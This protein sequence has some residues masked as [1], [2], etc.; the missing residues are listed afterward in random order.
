MSDEPFLS[1]GHLETYKYAKELIAPHIEGFKMLDALSDIDFYKEGL[2]NTPVPASDHIEPFLKEDIKN[3]W[4]YYCSAQAK[5][6]ANRF[7]SQ[8][9]TRNRILGTQMFKF[10]C[11]GT[12]HWGYNYFYSILSKGVINPFETVDSG[13]AFPAGDAFSVYPY[14]NEV[15]ESLRLKVFKD[16]VQ[17]YTAMNLLASYKGKDYVVKLI[18]EEIGEELRF[19][20]FPY[21]GNYI[22]NYREKIN[23]EL[24]NLA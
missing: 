12:L 13:G 11:V 17:D 21:F 18:E 24:K 19:D 10:D 7:L 4:V 20:Q 6:V 23:Q 22:I 8:P 2:I 3:R 9:S 5:D 14:G 16:A 15:V 1:L